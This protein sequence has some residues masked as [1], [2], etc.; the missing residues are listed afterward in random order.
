MNNESPLAKHGIKVITDEQ[1]PP[2]EMY[3]VPAEPPK[4]DKDREA[5]ERQVGRLTGLGSDD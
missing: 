2:G 4:T 1:V 3:L 5:W